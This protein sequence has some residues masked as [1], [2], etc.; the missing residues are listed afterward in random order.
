VFWLTLRQFRTQALVV[1]GALAAF[2]LALA[3]TGPHLVHLYDT[4]VAT[5]RQHDDCAGARAPFLQQ[6][7]FLR[8][9]TVVI[10]VA[11]ALIGMFWGAPL[12]A[13][14][15]E[16]GTFKLVWTQ[17]VSRSR[18]LAAKVG[19]V[20]LASVGAAGLLSLMVTW[21][22]SP[23]D[24]IAMSPFSP[25]F[26]DRRDIV[27]IGYAAFAFVLGVA[28][29]AVIRRTLAAMAATLVAFIGARVAVFEWI[30][31]RLM[32][33]LRI[34]APFDINP[35]GPGASGYGALNPADWVTSEQTINRAG[36]VI[37]QN[38]GIGPNGELGFNISNNGTITMGGVGTCPNKF[39]PPKIGSGAGRL[40]AGPSSGAVHAF[41]TCAD[42]LGIREVLTYQPADRYW[43]FQCYETAIFVGLALVLAG[44]TLW[45]VRR[46]LS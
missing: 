14:E 1:F 25:S 30:R 21:W 32:T 13:R 40:T 20:G 12:V 41:S 37:G 10:L 3:L 2:G 42:K 9:C 22:S 6:A 27:P 43:A 44:F 16:G 36:Q 5:C 4:T 38:G 39:T 28:A 29:G 17:G 34:T 7:G 33:P 18:W 31:P 35:S 26:F 11:P 45:W 46:R 8:H 24:R 19:L 23:F 15:L